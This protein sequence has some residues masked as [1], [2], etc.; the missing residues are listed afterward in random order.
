VAQLRI[1]VVLFLRTVRG[2]EKNGGRKERM[3]QGVE[4][5]VPFL[6]LALFL[7]AIRLPIGKKEG[8]IGG[9]GMSGSGLYSVSFSPR[10]YLFIRIRIFLEKR[11]KGKRG[12]NKVGEK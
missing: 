3:G 9:E 4:N 2:K 11:K 10:I 8:E 1:K 6:D 12:E 5:R 7:L